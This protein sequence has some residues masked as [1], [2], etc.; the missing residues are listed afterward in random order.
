VRRLRL[1]LPL[2]GIYVAL[3]VISPGFAP[4]G[5]EGVYLR[6]AERITHGYYSDASISD[7]DYLWYGPGLPALLSP[8]VAVGLPVELIRLLG[9][10]FL[11]GA[12][13]VFDLMLRGVLRANQALVGAYALG[14]YVPAWILVPHIYTEP[15]AL[16]CI[17]VGMLFMSR[18][19]A[20][21]S[22][23]HTV[24]AGAAFAGLALTKVA[25]GWIVTALLL[26]F[27]AAWLVQRAR[28]RAS[29]AGRPAA[30]FAIALVLCLPWLAFTYAKTDRVFYW[31]NSGGLSLYWIASPY[32][33]D[34]G[35]WHP[36]DEPTRPEHARFFRSIRTLG[37]VEHDVALQRRAREWITDDPVGYVR[38][39]MVNTGRILFGA[40]YPD[41][42]DQPL[43]P[44][45]YGV[46][47]ALLLGALA[48]SLP[49]LVRRRRELPPEAT[50][51]AAFAAVT[52]AFHVLLSADPRMLLPVVPA[53]LWIISVAIG[54]FAQVSE[55]RPAAVA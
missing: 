5:D 26:L 34:L 17:V 38:N 36:I 29:A 4:E 1:F 13:L 24:V 39:V 19:L 31:S 45:L 11:F 40:P 48:L 44:L 16:L 27:G 21:G 47:N 10:A 52:V 53:V 2:L 43:R 30:V 14:L 55:P 3:A 28:G 18:A 32:E 25:F 37:P 42:A 8:A 35:A 41:Q 54:R 12:V 6:Y 23:W 46:P 7:A 22:R 49:V 50:P 51:F 20:G 33:S 15:L 9:A